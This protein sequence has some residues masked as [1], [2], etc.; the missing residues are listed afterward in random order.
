M[1]L[2]AAC[3]EEVCIGLDRVAA[4]SYDAAPTVAPEISII[5]SRTDER[6]AA[7]EM[8]M[9]EKDLYAK[10]ETKKDGGTRISPYLVLSD[11]K[12]EVRVIPAKEAGLADYM[13]YYRVNLMNPNV[14]IGIFIGAMMVFVF[15]A[16]TMKAVG[17]AARS[18]VEEVRRQFR[19]IIGIMEGKA[20]PDYATCVEIATKGAQREMILPSVLSIVVPIVTGILFDVA[21]VM[22]LLV[23]A[24]STGFAVAIMMAASGGAWD[25]AKKWI[26]AGHHGGK[27]SPAHKAAVIGDPVG[28]PFKDTSGPSLNIL[29]KLM[30]MVSIVFVGLT[31]KFHPAIA[32]FFGL[33]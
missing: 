31:L 17:R 20:E 13:S 4:E 24:L 27:G 15:C 11:N 14:L 5:D 7:G 22:G 9:I 33:K 29:L 10:T 1:A 18:M 28:D 21:G 25:N 23:G 32:H 3:V 2:L 6:L 16:M 30:S 19:E 12:G 26:E 8:K